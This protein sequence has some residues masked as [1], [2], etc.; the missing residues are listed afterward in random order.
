MLSDL[1]HL[2]YGFYWIQ[3]APYVIT[4]FV[5]P[6]LDPSFFPLPPSVSIPMQNHQS[7][8]RRQRSICVLLLALLQFTLSSK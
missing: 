7:D 3:L 4:Q 2:I 6:S 8:D 1:D 5:S